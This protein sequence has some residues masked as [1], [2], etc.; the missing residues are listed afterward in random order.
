MRTWESGTV[1]HGYPKYISYPGCEETET[2]IPGDVRGY[3]ENRGFLVCICLEEKLTGVPD[4]RVIKITGR[5]GYFTPRMY[6]MISAMII[7]AYAVSVNLF[8]FTANH[9]KSR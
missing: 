3:A 9:A 2:D 4:P 6:M 7:T 8:A 5:E 1:L